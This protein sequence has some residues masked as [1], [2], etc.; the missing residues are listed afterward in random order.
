MGAVPRDT[1]P[2]PRTR[3]IPDRRR[4]ALTA[5]GTWLKVC[6]DQAEV[7]SALSAAAHLPEQG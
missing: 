3:R 4:R 5:P 6:G 7:V 1:E 2:G